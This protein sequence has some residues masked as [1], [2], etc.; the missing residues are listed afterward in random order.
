M[1]KPIDKD[2]RELLKE[3]ILKILSV[4][5]RESIGNI[6]IA[7]GIPKPSAYNL[8]LEAIN[9][10]DLCF[11]PEINIENIWKYEF[12]RLSKAHSKKEM[13]EKTIE[14]SSEL[15]FEEYI[16]L[17]KFRG[18]LPGDGEILRAIS[19]SSI[20]QFVAR[21]NGGYDIVMYAVSNGFFSMSKFVA[22]FAAAL[23]DYSV[24]SELNRIF[25]GFGFFPLRSK[26]IDEFKISELYRSI[27]LGLNGN[28]RKQIIEIAKAD[29]N[30]QLQ[31]IYAFERLKRTGMLNRVTY[32]E[33]APK[34]VVMSMIIIKAFNVAALRESA[35][36]LELDIVRKYE[37]EHTEYVFICDISNP[38]GIVA[39]TASKSK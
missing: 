7:M 13:L 18:K 5:G 28:G 21:I 9:D 3:R 32:Y 6:A 16:V 24:T 15:G 31:L 39:F 34:N 19:G 10:Y 4:N 14:K 29:K 23:K 27:L 25:K 8:V 30:Q 33:K 26:L 1:P 17:F 35:K 12:I 37:N 11:V 20:P 38:H 2:K 22:D 36:D